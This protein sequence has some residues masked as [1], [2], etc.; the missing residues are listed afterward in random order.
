MERDSTMSARA[1]KYAEDTLGVHRVYET[2]SE[3]LVVLD[4]LLSDL[5]KAQDRRRQLEDDYADR[6]VELIGEMRGVHPSF[7]DTKFKSEMKIWERE[8]TRLREVRVE[9]SK[10]RSELQGLDIDLE[11][12]R[13]RIRV[14]CSRMEQL[15]GYLR[16]LAEVKAGARTQAEKPISET[17]EEA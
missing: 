2:A 5:D 8:D 10:V 11:M 3:Q 13:M 4:E 15:G 9:L 12:A 17:G 16:Y 14:N 1:L 6:E 7:S